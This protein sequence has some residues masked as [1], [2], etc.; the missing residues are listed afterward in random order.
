MI[1]KHIDKRDNACQSLSDI[2]ELF[3]NNNSRNV[4][5]NIFNL[6]LHHDPI[7]VYVGEGL[8]AKRMP[9]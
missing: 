3:L 7:K 5:K 8:D 1:I 4:I 6:D 9:L 2:T